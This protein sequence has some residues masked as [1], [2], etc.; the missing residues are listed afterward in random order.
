MQPSCA[1]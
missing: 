1:E